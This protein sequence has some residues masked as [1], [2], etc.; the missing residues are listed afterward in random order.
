MVVHAQEDDFGC[1]PVDS[2]FVNVNGIRLYF[3]VYGEGE[4]LLLVEG[5]GYSTWMWFKQVLDLS[6]R[7]RVIVFDNRGVGYS[8]KPDEEYSIE[9]MASDAAGLLKEL[10]VERAAVLGVSMGGFIAQQ[11]ALDY[12]DVVSGLI[13]VCTAQEGVK[14]D[15]TNAWR[16]I[17]KTLDIVPGALELAVSL[18]GKASGNIPLTPFADPVYNMRRALSF[19]FTNEYFGSHPDEIDR[20]FKW[21]LAN[22]Q[23][24]YAWKRQF[25]AGLEFDASERVG[26]IS[27]PTLVIAGAGDRII[28]I[29][30][31][32]RLAEQIPSSQFVQL[33]DAGHLLFIEQAELFNKA[34]LDFLSQVYGDE[35]ELEKEEI[36]EAPGKS[37]WQKFQ[38]WIMNT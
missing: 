7:H 18:C 26:E 17:L 24:T 27:V 31:S 1:G 37:L 33:P 5:L 4:P 13:L 16:M 21:R 25:S 12:P 30:S 35:P 22:P 19:G 20:I 28:P 23:P 3:E 8:D 14:N 9:L 6:S 34:V 36:R 38:G 29:E 10:E 2:G 32:G 15:G 11:L